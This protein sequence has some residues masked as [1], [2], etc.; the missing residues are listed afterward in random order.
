[1]DKK[2]QK[3]FATRAAELRQTIA[4]HDHNYYELDKPTITDFEY[5]KIFSELK[6]LEREH[7]ELVTPDSPTQ[8]VS[9]GVIDAFKKAKHRQPMISLQN[10]Y[11]PEDIV[12]FDQR[13]KKF[14]KSQDPIEYYCEPKFDGLA[15]E[16]IYENGAL[17]RALTRGNGDIGEDVTHNIKT[18]RSIPLVIDVKSKIFEVRGEV[19]ILKDDF[20]RLNEQQQEDGEQPFA[21]PRNAA[22]GSIR[23]LDSSIAASR[24][25]H[26][27]C[28]A[29]GV[30]DGVKFKTHSDFVQALKRL[31]FSTTPISS[32]CD[33]SEG[34]VEF[35]NRVLDQRHK[36]EF[37]IDGIVVKINSFALQEELGN[38]ARSP[39]WATAAKFQ[40]AQAQTKITDIVVQVGRTGALT[41]VAVMEPVAVG[42]VTV[43]HATLHNQDEVTRKD[44]RVNDTVIVQRA[45][46]VIPEI[47]SVVLEKRPKNSEPFHI[48]TKCPEC[49]TKTEKAE[50]EV[51]QR[52]TNPLCPAILK[53]SLK[54]FV[55]RRAMNIDKVGD[56]LVDQFVEA[57]LVEKYSDFYKIT[58]KDLL[59]LDRQGE[60]SAQNILD[61][62]AESRTP[63]L[64]QFIFALGIRFVGEQ[65]AKVL[66]S[67][68]R[69]IDNVL[70]AQEDELI[71]VDGIGEKVA[72]SVLTALQRPALK[73]EIQRL[74][75]L[76]VK[77]QNPTPINKNGALKGLNIV[78]TGTLPMGRDEIKDLIEKHGG[79]SASSVTKKTNYVL[80]GDSA[81]SKLD[82]A[83][84]LEIP[85]LDWEE[86]KKILEK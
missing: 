8:R 47:V 67:S 32:I 14:L 41:P 83:R 48:P 61:S 13:V 50:G 57:K 39:R 5:D 37:D 20:L 51:V 18:I 17:V 64:G 59:D 23:Q 56:K 66:A 63:T 25:L 24:P 35:Y 73:K 15:I 6:D 36:L 62:I 44:V 81:G 53:E 42:G 52:C 33:S 84:E 80:A 75:D 85:I 1:M 76:G 3:K 54:H 68:F 74:Q 29:P 72:H 34:A 10:S 2:P 71:N 19:I 38:I 9:G 12:A 26:M 58:K 4:T 69:S 43:T 79:K 70:A 65:T 55:A 30:I 21:N 11:S 49:G 86:F 60:K 82:R 22:A 78:I 46:D 27:F 7:P 16:L 31:G 45:G 40:P 77:I 28:Y